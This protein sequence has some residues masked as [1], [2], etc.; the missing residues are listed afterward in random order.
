MDDG[1]L[2]AA[3]LAAGLALV[4]AFLWWVSGDLR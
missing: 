3:I 2:V 1:L 4:L